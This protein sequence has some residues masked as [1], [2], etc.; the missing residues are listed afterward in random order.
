MKVTGGLDHGGEDVLKPDSKGY[1]ILAEFVRRVNAP[2]STTPRP[3]VDDKNL[4]PFFDGVVDAG[5]R[6]GCCGASRCRWPAGCRPTAEQAAVA[7]QGAGR[8]CRRCS[9]R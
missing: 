6:S 8:R 3:V 4:P 1:L 5:R 2:P 9:T 7:E